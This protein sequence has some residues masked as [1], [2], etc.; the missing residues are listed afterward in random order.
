E[1]FTRNHV[2]PAGEVLAIAA[3]V[4][5]REDDLG[6]GR[7]DI[8]ADAHQRHMILQPDRILLQRTVVIELEMVVVVVGVLVV[9]V[10]DV[11][12]IEMV[13]EAVSP[14]WF[15]VVGIGH[16]LTLLNKSMPAGGRASLCPAEKLQSAWP[17]AFGR[18]GA[19][20]AC[21]REAWQIRQS[22]Q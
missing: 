10:D 9:L 20:S 14:L 17:G 7:A 11:L 2:V 12:A 6:A 5:A 4:D 19:G 15:L 21:S 13:G 18:T 3:Q 16:Q 22:F 1:C 8:D